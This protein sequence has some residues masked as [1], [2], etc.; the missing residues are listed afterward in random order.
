MPKPDADGCLTVKAQSIRKVVDP[1]DQPKDI[2]AA[3]SYV[4]GEPWFD[5]YL[6]NEDERIAS[7]NSAV[8]GR[9]NKAMPP[10]VNDFPQSRFVNQGGG[11]S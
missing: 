6:K 9:L 10:T 5:K 4:H 7:A 2:V 1:L 11:F 3:T 8:R